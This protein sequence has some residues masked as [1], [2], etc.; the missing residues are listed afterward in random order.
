[1][2]SIINKKKLPFFLV[3]TFLN[4]I[5][6]NR[7]F[8]VP[9]IMK[10]QVVQIKKIKKVDLWAVSKINEHSCQSGAVYTLNWSNRSQ[11]SLSSLPVCSAGLSYL[12][13]RQREL[14]P[15]KLETEYWQYVNRTEKNIFLRERRALK[16]SKWI[17]HT[18]LCVLVF[19]LC[20]L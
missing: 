11:W 3:K 16:E 19:P 20:I 7:R 14:K 12:L 13:C 1:M 2:Q 9:S 5:A 17:D 6:R 4:F 10:L 18:R 8:S 15:F